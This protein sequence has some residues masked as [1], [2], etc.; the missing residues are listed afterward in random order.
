MSRRDAYSHLD[1]WSAVSVSA[2]INGDKKADLVQIGWDQDF[3]EQLGPFI[4]VISLATGAPTV[5]SN[6]QLTETVGFDD[7]L[8]NFLQYR[9]VAG[10]FY[11]NDQYQLIVINERTLG[12][13]VFQWK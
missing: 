7:T 6:T 4:R 11:G 5:L 13:H 12:V 10:R 3:A 2:D 1:L 9:M 8:P